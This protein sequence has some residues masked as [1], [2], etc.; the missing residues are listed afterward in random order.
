MKHCLSVCVRQFLPSKIY[1]FFA[2]QLIVLLE[3]CNKAGQKLLCVLQKEAWLL[4]S[5]SNFSEVPVLHFLVFP[6]NV[7]TLLR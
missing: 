1:S 3:R 4:E 5:Y 2:F 7:H 6:E